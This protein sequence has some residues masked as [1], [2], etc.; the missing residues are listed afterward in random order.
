MGAEAV[1]EK[2][3]LAGLILEVGLAAWVPFVNSYPPKLLILQSLD[4]IQ[5]AGLIT[6]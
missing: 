5:V 2:R 4:F 6:R 1:S 3:L